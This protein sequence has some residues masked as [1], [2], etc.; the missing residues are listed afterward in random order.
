MFYKPCLLRTQRSQQEEEAEAEGG[1]E[2]EEDGQGT[3]LE[4]TLMP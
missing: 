1:A 2:E 4:W 3:V